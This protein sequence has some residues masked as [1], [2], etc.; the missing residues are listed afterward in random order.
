[1]LLFNVRG[2][3]ISSFLY[4]VSGSNGMSWFGL[5][6]WCSEWGIVIWNDVKNG[7]IEFFMVVFY[8]R[9]IIGGWSG[10]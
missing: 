6:D 10:I 7:N 5:S 9:R 1:M 2:F 4:L 8:C 3:Y